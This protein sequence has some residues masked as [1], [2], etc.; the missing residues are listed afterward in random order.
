MNINFLVYSILVFGKNREI[1]DVERLNR[2]FSKWSHGKVKT[3]EISWGYVMEKRK[4]AEVSRVY[5][6]EK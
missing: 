2:N 5:V 6:M 4:T 1:L 3:A